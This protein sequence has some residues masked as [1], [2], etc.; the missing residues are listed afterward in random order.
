LGKYARICYRGRARKRRLAALTRG[1][2]HVWVCS[3]SLFF[4]SKIAHITIVFLVKAE[5]LGEGAGLTQQEVLDEVYGSLNPCERYDIDLRLRQ[6]RVLLLGG[7]ETTAGNVLSFNKRTCI[8][9]I[10]YTLLVSMTVCFEPSVTSTGFLNSTVGF[11]RTCAES[12]YP[13]EAS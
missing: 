2:N 8:L 9:T 10:A 11:Y 12:R 6:A 3:V 1:T 7:F 13:N 5:G 4:I